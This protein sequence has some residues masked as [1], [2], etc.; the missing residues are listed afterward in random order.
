MA[1]TLALTDPDQPAFRPLTRL[2]SLFAQRDGAFT[3]LERIRLKY[4]GA[5]LLFKHPDPNYEQLIAKSE[6]MLA[7]SE[8]SAADQ[9]NAREIAGPG[10]SPAEVLSGLAR[11]I[12]KDIELILSNRGTDF[13]KA[14]DPR[15]SDRFHDLSVHVVGPPDQLFVHN[16][17]Q[18]LP[19]C[20]F[21]V[22]G[23]PVLLERGVCVSPFSFLEGPL[24]VGPD[25]RI[26]NARITGGCVLGR[27]VRV[28]GEIENSVLGDFTNKHHEGFLGHSILAPWV[29][30]GALATTSDLKNNYGAVRLLVPAAD[31]PDARPDQ[32]LSLETGTIKF[33]SLIGECAKIGIGTML[34]T[35]TVIDVGANVFGGSAQRYVP[36]FSW[37]QEGVYRLKRFLEDSARVFDRR[38]QTPWPGFA[39]L[40][41]RVHP[42]PQ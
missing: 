9:R 24:Y 16:E 22:R 27:N 25:S 36:P 21:D 20:V 30:V 1:D 17:C 7:F 38:G 26:D 10:G 40:A 33:G 3:L 11:N 4:P 42:G 8:S 2:R 32:L 15:N 28:G 31:P 5:T 41:Q 14:S 37:G 13:G 29:N 34:S 39:Q 23:G 18:I 6:G 35:G 19:G 12:E